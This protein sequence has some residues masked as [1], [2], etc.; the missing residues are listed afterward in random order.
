MGKSVLLF[1]I[2]TVTF[3]CVDELTIK[4]VEAESFV[5]ISGEVI[6][7]GSKPVVAIATVRNYSSQQVPETGALV[8]ISDDSGIVFKLHEESPG[9]YTVATDELFEAVTGDR[10]TLHVQMA[11]GRRYESSPQ[12]MVENIAIESVSFTYKKEVLNFEDIS[13]PHDA[14]GILVH[15]S[16]AIAHSFYLRWRWH[17]V[18]ETRTFPEKRTKPDGPPPSVTPD[19]PAC[20]GYV[21]ASGAAV[22]VGPCYCCNCWVEEYSNDV[23]VLSSAEYDNAPVNISNIAVDTRRFDIR[24]YI[25]VE[26]LAMN[27]EAFEFFSLISKQQKAA[28]NIFQPNAIR[29]RGNVRSMSNPDETVLGFFGTY[30][31]NRK[32]MFIYQSD[33][34]ETPPAPIDVND[35]CR[36][37]SNGRNVKPNFW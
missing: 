23:T 37:L 27:Q 26:Q 10:Y 29:I 12:E 13:K 6:N 1:F 9:S 3:S 15:P 21:V 20:S 22:K 35:D 30:A 4:E 11:D 31:I 33:L 5:I 25:D 16:S 34:P 28:Q 17:G 18:Y 19:P 36:R 24:Y 7:D 2:L 14:V 32:S 8:T